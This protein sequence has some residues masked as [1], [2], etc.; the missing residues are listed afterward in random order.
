MKDRLRS[1]LPLKESVTD[2]VV[3]T[4]TKQLL[5]LE[6]NGIPPGERAAWIWSDMRTRCR[7]CW[8]R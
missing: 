2:G 5:L 8:S 3:E 4:A 1:S 6:M 7:R